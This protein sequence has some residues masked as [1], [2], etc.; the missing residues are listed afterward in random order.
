MGG[1]TS[2]SV[3][4]AKAT[5]AWVVREADRRGRS[6]VI[7]V[8]GRDA[9]AVVP[10]SLLQLNDAKSSRR[11]KRIARLLKLLLRELPG[12]ASRRR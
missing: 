2:L 3:R 6:F 4:Q 7:T 10:V 11:G 1:H 12:A 9:A 5:F 8:H